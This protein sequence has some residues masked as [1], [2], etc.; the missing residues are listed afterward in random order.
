[1]DA[2]NKEAGYSL[3]ELIATVILVGIA[4]PGLLI[5]L[6]ESMTDTAKNEIISQAIQLAGQKM[7]QICADKNELTRGFSYIGTPG[8]YPGETINQFTISVLVQ[9]LVLN[10]VEALEVK[11]IVSHPAMGE[12]YNL[13]HIFTDYGSL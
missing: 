3:V 13:N 6:T 5:F 1:M 8:R 2:V 10:N 12:S 9:S 7:E 4:V 11:V